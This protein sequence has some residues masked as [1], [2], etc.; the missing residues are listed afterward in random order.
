MATAMM[1]AAPQTAQRV[2]RAVARAPESA[3][4]ADLVTAIKH[5]TYVRASLIL[6]ARKRGAE[7]APRTKARVA[8]INEAL[9]RYAALVDAK[10]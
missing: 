7:D 3:T 8:K 6:T 10:R 2:A 4:V 9:V 5:L 1:D